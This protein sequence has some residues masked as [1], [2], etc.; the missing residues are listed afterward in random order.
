M[1]APSEEQQHAATAAAS[2]V[3]NTAGNEAQMHEIEHDA[4]AAAPD[5]AA[6]TTANCSASEKTTDNDAT[7]QPAVIYSDEKDLEKAQTDSK[8]KEE[9]ED[10]NI[11][12]WDGPDDPKNPYNWPTW[13]KV[14]NCALISALT[15]V[16]PLA[17]C[18]LFVLSSNIYASLIH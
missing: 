9:P 11:V 2:A 17:S 10:P 5:T 3:T 16:T 1:A 8:V 13:K 7:S 15:F 18:K 12:F 14:F 4:A 6:T